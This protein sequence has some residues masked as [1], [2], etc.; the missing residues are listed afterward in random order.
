MIV[1]ANPRETIQKIFEKKKDLFSIFF[2]LMNF[3]EKKNACKNFS[4][5]NAKFLFIMNTLTTTMTSKSTRI[6]FCCYGNL[7]DTAML[8][9][10]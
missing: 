5:Y 1:S 4:I 9:Q 6:S 3:H 10:T 2:T 7:A 8:T